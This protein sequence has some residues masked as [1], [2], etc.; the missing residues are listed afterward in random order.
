MKL[1]GGDGEGGAAL[2]VGEAGSGGAFFSAL[3]GGFI[4]DWPG[5]DEGQVG[6]GTVL[7]GLHD[8][9]FVCGGAE[10]DLPKQAGVC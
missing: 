2:V 3:G 4:D 6:L 8:L 1:G 10:G 7:S 9:F 5:D